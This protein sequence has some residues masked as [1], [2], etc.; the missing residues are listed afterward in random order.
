MAQAPKARAARGQVEEAGNTQMGF[1]L[2]ILNSQNENHRRVA[3]T[4]EDK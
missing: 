2:E 3:F 1:S 4:E